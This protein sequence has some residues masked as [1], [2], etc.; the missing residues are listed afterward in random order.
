LDFAE[1]DPV[2]RTGW[3]HPE[4][5]GWYAARNVINPNAARDSTELTFIAFLRRG[6]KWSAEQTPELSKLQEAHMDN[7]RSMARQGKLAL[8]GPFVDGKELR[9]VFVFR[10]PSLADAQ[11]LADNDPMVQVGRLVFDVHPW[12]IPRHNLR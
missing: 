1:A 4:V 10:V 6:P 12:L 2:V 5:L 8:A 11:K 3:L 7:I 9:G